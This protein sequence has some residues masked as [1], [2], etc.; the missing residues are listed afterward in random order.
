MKKI[1]KTNKNKGTVG[2]TG[3]HIGTK[4]EGKLTTKAMHMGMKQPTTN[5]HMTKMSG[6]VPSFNK[7]KKSLSKTMGYH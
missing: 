4:Q 3:R 1:I 2:R 6:K 5:K 7:I